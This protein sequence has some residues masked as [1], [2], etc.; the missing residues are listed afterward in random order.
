MTRPHRLTEGDLDRIRQEIATRET[1]IA[2][3]MTADQTQSKR[4][5]QV[6]AGFEVRRAYVFTSEWEAICVTPS[7]SEAAHAYNLL[8]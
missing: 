4:L 2:A 5:M 8:S 6:G 7:L 1:V 3:A